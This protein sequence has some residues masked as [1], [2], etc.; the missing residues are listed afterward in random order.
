M[1][2][3]IKYKD[4]FAADEINHIQLLKEELS[5]NEIARFGTPEQEK[6]IVSLYTDT[7]NPLNAAQIGKQFNVSGGTITSILVRNGVTIRDKKKL[8]PEQEKEI[9]SLYTDTKNPLNAA[10]IAKQFNVS[11]GTIISILVRNGVTIRDKKKLT[12]EQEKEI[13]DLY[14]SGVSILD[15]QKTFK[16][17]YITVKNIIDN[18]IQNP[19]IQKRILTRSRTTIP[20]G[21]SSEDFEIYKTLSFTSPVERKKWFDKYRLDRGQCTTCGDKTLPN[22]Y[23]QKSQRFCEKHGGVK[24]QIKR[25]KNMSDDDYNIYKNMH[26]NNKKERSVW[27]V[28]NRK[29][30]GQCI[31]FNCAEKALLNNVLCQKHYDISRGHT[32]LWKNRKKNLGL[33]RVC[34]NKSAM[35]NPDGTY[36][37]RCKDCHEKAVIMNKNIYNKNKQQ[38]VDYKG[39]K[40]IHC[41]YNKS[42][43]ALDFHHVDRTQKDKNWFNLRRKPLE[44]LKNELDKCELLCKNCHRKVHFSSD[45]KHKQSQRRRNKKQACLDYKKIDRCEKCSTKSIITIYDFHHINPN[46]KDKQFKLF[47]SWPE[48]S[49]WQPGQELHDRIKKEL[50]KCKVLCTNCHAE[51]HWDSATDDVTDEYDKEIPEEECTDDNCKHSH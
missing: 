3:C 2:D 26:F 19:E 25:P 22:P 48:W 1:C 9:V 14:T 10:Q 20:N 15:I 31:Y 37:L 45:L 46:S 39:G 18:V 44:Q 34:G 16:T 28:N 23:T 40:C 43:G 42:N 21:M 38:A 4:F 12:P 11:G 6:E 29:E 47:F 24:M 8:T 50:D 33:C 49:G 36:K 35:Q 17:S 41:G 30:R 32:G 51:E 7:K 5:L 13:I 27:I